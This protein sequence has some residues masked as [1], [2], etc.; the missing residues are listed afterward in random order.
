[1]SRLLQGDVGSG[2]TVVAA[3]A[4]LVVALV[5]QQAALMAPTEILSEQHY[6]TLAGM[7]GS[8]GLNVALLTGSV[9]RV[10]KD[11][12]YAALAAGEIDVIVGTHAIIQ[13]DVQ[14]DQLALV[15]VDEQ[16]RFGVRQRGT[17]RGKG[18]NPH[19]LVMSATPIPRSLAL[20]LYGDLDLS[21]IDEMPPGRQP[22][23]TRWFLPA[24]RERAYRFLRLTGCQGLPGVHYLPVG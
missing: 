1:M 6:K 9:P 8:Q 19:M 12:I 11:A 20:T 24:E 22:I 14:F 18:Y 13:Q 16:H 10:E 4:M 7:L 17:L 3:A 23:R 21:V 5:G 15:I 2:K